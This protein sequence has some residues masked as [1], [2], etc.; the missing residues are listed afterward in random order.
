MEKYQKIEKIG[1][2][3]QLWDPSS[4]DTNLFDR[5]DF[6]NDTQGPMVSSTKLVSLFTPTG[7]SL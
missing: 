4:I 6:H 7:S 3:M 5:P 1:E 2:G